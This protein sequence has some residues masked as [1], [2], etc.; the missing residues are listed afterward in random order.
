MREI[1]FRGLDVLT[2][3]WV[4]G[5]LLQTGIVSTYI[6]PQ[7]LISN[8]L[9][10]WL[11]DKDTVG[12]YTGLKVKNDQPLYEGDIV[13][14]KFSVHKGWKRGWIHCQKNAFVEY[15]KNEMCFMFVADTEYGKQY[16][17]FDKGIRQSYK[18]IGNIHENPELLKGGENK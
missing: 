10:Q 8:Y 13:P 18:I 15:V 5:N 3:T 9:P 14:V 6:V 17:P 1:K 7:N 16:I 12:E 11:V 2:G 4:Y